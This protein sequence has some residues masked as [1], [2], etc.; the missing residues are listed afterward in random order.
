VQVSLV[1][2]VMDEQ[3]EQTRSAVAEHAADSYCP[4]GQAPEHAWH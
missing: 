4:A 2:L 1:Q 3:L